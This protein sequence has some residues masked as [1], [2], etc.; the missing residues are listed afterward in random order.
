MSTIVEQSKQQLSDEDL[1]AAL[2]LSAADGSADAGFED[3]D[4]EGV[5]EVTGKRKAASLKDAKDYQGKK[6]KKRK[7]CFDSDSGG[8]DDSDSD[9]DE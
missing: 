2:S 4:G 1:A 6:G 8:D 3:D 5:P 7:R 9:S